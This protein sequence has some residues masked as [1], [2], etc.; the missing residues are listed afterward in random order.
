MRLHGG[1]RCISGGG[2]GVRKDG[3]KIFERHFVLLILNG[4]G[5]VVSFFAAR[6]SA[7]VYRLSPKQLG[8]GC[9][10]GS[11]M[12]MNYKGFFPKGLVPPRIRRCRRLEN[13]S[14]PALR[15]RPRLRR[16]KAWQH[17][18]WVKRVD[19]RVT[20]GGRAQIKK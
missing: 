4:K 15:L 12:T 16:P 18:V 17:V 8:R 5:A 2:K 19:V 6:D 20:L 7:R 14:R 3:R 11:R 1:G 9:C 10:N 13:T